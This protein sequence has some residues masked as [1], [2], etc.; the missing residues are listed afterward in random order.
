MLIMAM[1]PLLIGVG[2]LLFSRHEKTASLYLAGF[3]LCIALS[4][5]PQVIGYAGLYDRL[6][7]LTYFPVFYVTLWFGP[8]LYLHGYK[9][10]RGGPL[11][12]RVYLLIPGVIQII[13]YL[14]AFFGLGTGWSDY[15]AKWAYNGAVHQ[16]YVA[17]VD[18][19]LSLGLLAFALIA[20]WRLLKSYNTYLDN[21]QSQAIDFDPIWL[22]RIILGAVIG[23]V[24]YFIGEIVSL[25]NPGNFRIFFVFQLAVLLIT[26]WLAIEAI[27]RLNRAFPKLPDINVTTELVESAENTLSPTV[28]T[29]AQEGL[30]ALIKNKVVSEDWF[31]ESQISIRDLAKRLGTNESYISRALNQDIGESFNRFINKH[32][33]EHAKALIQAGDGSML[34]IAL[35]SGFN[36]KA[37][38]NRV[39]QNIAGQTPSAF[40]K[41]QN[42]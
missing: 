41:S 14:W 36:S 34:M 23:G 40:K 1:L 8:L 15:Q 19:F 29:S 33:V 6:P 7:G 30:A 31:L 10:M 13:Y 3:F 21:T 26:A 16:P 5:G 35:D 9:L 4:A 28:E 32:R 38:F 18:T 20:V 24:I 12:W 17:P 27:F 2:V 11:G 42:P 22:R 25:L 37:T 39:F